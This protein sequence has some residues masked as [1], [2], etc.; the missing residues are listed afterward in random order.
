MSGEVIGIDGLTDQQREGARLAAAGWRGVDIAEQLDVA[1]ETVSR[2]RK[3]PE[4]V[5]A[6]EAILSEARLE[7]AGRMADLTDKALDVIEDTLDYK[8]DR[9]IKLRAAI[10]LLQLSGVGRV[11]SSRS[12]QQRP[13]DQAATLANID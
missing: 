10:A 1:P 3:K 11:T 5:A 2:W 9:R 7:V 6:I 8:Y 12:G 13:S 4:Y